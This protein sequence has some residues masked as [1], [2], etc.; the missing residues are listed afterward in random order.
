MADDEITVPANYTA[1]LFDISGRVAV[2]TGAGSGLGAAIAIGYAQLGVTVV[3]ADINAA[4]MA[5]TLATITEQ[6]GK[7]VAAELDVTKRDRCFDLARK[8]KADHGSVDILVNSAGSAFR[9]PAE[10]FPEDKFNFILDL[11]LKGTYF[12]CQAFG[13]VM[14]AQGRGSII[15]LASIGSFNAYP[16]ASAYLASKGG[17]LQMTKALA[18][19]W[20]DRGVRVNGIGPTLMESPLT[21]AAA[22]RS[23]ITADFIK[24]RMLRPRLGLPRELIGTAVF[25][26]SDASEL[27]TGHIVMCD[28]GYLTA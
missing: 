6:G 21:K 3:L 17:V 10:E 28:D 20:R 16:W 23:S 24:A 11:N 18:L 2:V 27:V 15:N 7:A 26:A 25:L 8:V 5:A 9:S 13:N 19:E 12:C 1:G 22:S 4:G 14:L